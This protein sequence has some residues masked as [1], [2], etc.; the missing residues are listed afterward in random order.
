MIQIEQLEIKEIVSKTGRVRKQRYGLFKCEFCKGSVKTTV[1]SGRKAKSCS[2]CR[3]LARSAEI[4]RK[5]GFGNFNLVKELGVR[6]TGILE[7]RNGTIQRALYGIFECKNCNSHVEL[8]YSKTRKYSHCTHC[9]RVT[10]GMSGTRPYIIWRGMKDRCENSKNKKYH[11]YGGKGVKVCD[12]WQKFESFWSDMK[13]TYTENM[14]IDRKDSSK[15]YCPGN[16]RWLSREDNSSKTTKRRP[17]EQY[18]L[19]AGSKEYLCKIATYESILNA[20]KICNIHPMSIQSVL[21]GK[22]M[23]AGGYGWKYAN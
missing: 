2:A 13:D 15:D 21:G 20:S 11:I 3:G 23:T 14:T 4:V 12:K 10:H 1:E 22:S 5:K 16:C 8:S 19:L 17:V 7:K 6:E 9:K 18:E